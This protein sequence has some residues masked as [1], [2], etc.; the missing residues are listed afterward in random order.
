M[1]NQSTVVESRGTDGPYRKFVLPT[2]P[3][4]EIRLI[5]AE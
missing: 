3:P 1:D 2:I 5:V 4:W